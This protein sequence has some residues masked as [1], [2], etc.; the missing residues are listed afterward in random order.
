MTDLMQ[1]FLGSKGLIPDQSLQLVTPHAKGYLPFEDTYQNGKKLPEERS[2]RLAT[3]SRPLR[4]C[5]T[6][7]H[8]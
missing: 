4:R 8:D 6:L 7:V 3:L 2:D 5:L 1:A